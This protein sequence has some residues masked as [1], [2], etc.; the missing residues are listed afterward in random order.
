MIH[1]FGQTGWPWDLPF[2][3][4]QVMELQA[5][6]TRPT[7]SKMRMLWG[8]TQKLILPGKA[9]NHL[10]H[11]SLQPPGPI[12]FTL[13]LGGIQSLLC[14]VHHHQC[15]LLRST[16]VY[17]MIFKQKQKEN[18][19]VK[20][21]CRRTRHSTEVIGQIRAKKIF[22][23]KTKQNNFNGK[24]PGMHFVVFHLTYSFVCGDAAPSRREVFSDYILHG[25]HEGRL[26][27]REGL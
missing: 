16:T 21:V 8:S 14:L 20:H 9:L 5:Q 4:S 25:Y 26:S 22:F 17:E 11:L 6:T 12:F 10:S 7:F 1:W 19:F 15:A 3:D 24:F 27:P 2:S 23:F 13:T 18:L